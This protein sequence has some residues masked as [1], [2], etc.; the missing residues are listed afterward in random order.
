MKTALVIGGGV[1]G[2][3]AS[4]QLMQLGGW[5]VTLVE[6]A[7]FLGAGLRTFHYGGH[8]YT[9]GPRH[10]LT[11]NRR[12]YDYMNAICP[13]RSCA[14]HQFVTYVER[15]NAFYNYPI[16]E[17]DIARM[18]DRDKIAAERQAATGVAAAK[19][20]EEYWIGSVGRTLY[21]KFID[22][23]N[24]KMW[25]VDDNSEIDTFNWSPK[26]VTIKSG[27]RA[28]WDTAISAYPYAADG[29]NRYFDIATVGV[30]VLLST[31]IERYDIPNRTVWIKG[32]KKS[33]DLIVSTVSPDE[34][35]E[36]CYGELRFIGRDFHKIV[37]PTEH[38]FP[39]HVYFLYYAN[40]EPFTRLVEYKKF[41]HHK[42]PTSLVGMEI[43]SLNGKHYPLPFKA[44]Q[45]LA[46]KYLELMPDNVYSV[47][48]A[49]SYRYGLDVDD[50]L[51]QAM[52]MATQIKEGGR[53]YPVPLEIWR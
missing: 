39:E 12:V 16:H 41:T 53:D 14:E 11:Q 7:P 3:A 27:P 30:N 49:G 35:F 10:F 6:A 47:G 38:V 37:F 45:E 42:S 33:Y 25:L 4:H 43:P 1:A 50:C 29:Y 24:K 2:C 15:D 51:E 20:L 28:A 22:K 8:P 31:R 52:V 19:N 40:D 34:L 44:D 21:E 9:F 26:G 18:P 32:E 36:R 17:D 48:R 5:N 13:L 46:R 23:Y